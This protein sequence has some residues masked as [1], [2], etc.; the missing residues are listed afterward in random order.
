MK[1]KASIGTVMVMWTFTIF[2]AMFWYY[3]PAYYSFLSDVFLVVALICA[4]VSFRVSIK[5]GK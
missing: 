3:L 1:G 4:A 2:L 5:R